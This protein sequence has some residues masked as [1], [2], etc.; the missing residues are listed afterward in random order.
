VYVRIRRTFA[1]D[2]RED[3]ASIAEYRT[4][5]G[6]G[7]VPQG[8]IDEITARGIRVM[9]IYLTGN[10]L[11]M[12]TE[13]DGSASEQGGRPDA[14][15]SDATQ[16]WETLMWTFQKPLPWSRPGEKWVEAECIFRL[17]EGTPSTPAPSA[18]THPQPGSLPNCCT[19]ER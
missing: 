8:V 13:T 1:L 3:P 16:S 17:P 14:G 12:I 19:S 10:R 2:L 6:P 5:H 7:A 18:P 15:D 9:E 11:I 4:W